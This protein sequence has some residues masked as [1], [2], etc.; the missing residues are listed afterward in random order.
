MR[1]KKK[2]WTEARTRV[3]KRKKGVEMSPPSLWLRPFKVA[4]LKINLAYL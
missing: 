1:C 3:V 4:T 2:R